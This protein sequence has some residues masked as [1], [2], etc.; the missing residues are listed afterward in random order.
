MLIKPKQEEEKFDY[1]ESL[2]SGYFESGRAQG[3]SVGVTFNSIA[4]GFENS[5]PMGTIEDEQELNTNLD[6]IEKRALS[7]VY[8]TEG[9]SKTEGLRE[10]IEVQRIEVPQ[11][12]PKKLVQS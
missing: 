7:V 8:T 5:I 6:R 1:K 11:D 9:S 10:T 2:L 3:V 4:T 12:D